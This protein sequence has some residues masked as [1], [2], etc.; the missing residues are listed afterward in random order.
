MI[1]DPLPP[2]PVTILPA[3]NRRLIVLAKSRLVRAAQASLQQALAAI[4]NLFDALA[5]DF[6]IGL[7]SK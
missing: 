4:P 2:I 7:H 5:H 1:A 6:A 3:L